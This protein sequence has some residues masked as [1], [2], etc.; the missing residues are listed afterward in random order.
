[1]NGTLLYLNNFKPYLFSTLLK[2]VT[3]NFSRTLKSDASSQKNGRVLLLEIS[4]AAANVIS[5]E[6]QLRGA[7]E[8]RR[9]RETCKYKSYC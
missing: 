4:R 2:A 7:I 5:E 8:R 9:L 6:E 3:A 1:M